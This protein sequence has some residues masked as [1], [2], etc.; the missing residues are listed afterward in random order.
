MVVAWPE[1]EVDIDERL[2]RELIRDQHPDLAGRPL[3]FV[4]A[5]FDNSTWRLGDDLA[6]RLPRR[7]VAAELMDHEQRWLPVLAPDLPLPIPAP[8]RLGIPAPDYPWG[9]SIVP[10]MEGEPGDC[11]PVTD[12]HDAGRRLGGFLRA[13][14]REAPPDA[15]FNAWRSVT[16]ASRTRAFEDRLDAAGAAVDGP[17]LRT[18]WDAAVSATPHPRLPTW[19]HGDLHPANTIVSGGT[20]VGVIDFGDLCAGDPATD[21]GAAWMSIPAEAFRDFGSAYGELDQ[22]LVAR[23]LGWATLFALMFLG[24][25]S[26]GRPSYEGVAVRALAGVDAASRAL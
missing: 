20:V 26:A 2:V 21:I 16:L 4:D 5:G 19:V 25:A 3:R 14:H 15:P 17:S 13:L 24:L 10:W 23:A 12:A 11:S 22:A 1:A 6:V 18:V 8:V 9:W 7:A